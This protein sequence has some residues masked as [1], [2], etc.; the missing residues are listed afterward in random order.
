MVVLDEIFALLHE[1]YPEARIVGHSE[2]DARKA[3]PCLSPPASVEYAY[4]FNTN[5]HE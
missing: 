1:V 4:F 5:Y 3:C 2:L